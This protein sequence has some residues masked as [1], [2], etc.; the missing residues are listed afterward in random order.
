MNANGIIYLNDWAACDAKVT[1]LVTW[2]FE[3]QIF[4]TQGKITKWYS[5]CSF[6]RFIFTL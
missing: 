2:Q 1:F 6:D 5:S 3:G 4:P